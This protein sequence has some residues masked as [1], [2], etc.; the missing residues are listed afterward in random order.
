MGSLNQRVLRRHYI[1][2]SAT[3]V[4]TSFVCSALYPE[5]TEG[6]AKGAALKMLG[7]YAA[8]VA[9]GVTAGVI[10]EKAVKTQPLGAQEPESRSAEPAMLPPPPRISGYDFTLQWTVREG[11]YSGVLEMQGTSGTFR[12]RKPDGLII[13]QA[14]TASRSDNRHEVWLI[15]SDPTYAGTSDRVSETVY[16]ADRFR[17]IEVNGAWTV[18]DQCDRD[19]CAPV[20]VTAART[21]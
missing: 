18:A 12:V 20:L 2:R 4:L 14:V 6:Q 9:G 17:L 5:T 15:G 1:T 16:L 7:R 8:E 11:T 10:L 13:D 3:I 19:R 21:F